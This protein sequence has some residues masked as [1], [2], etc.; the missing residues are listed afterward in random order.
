MKDDEERWN[1]SR[2]SLPKTFSPSGVFL[3]IKLGKLLDLG[4]YGIA[5]IGN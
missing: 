2:K 3:G 5:K 4:L 1:S